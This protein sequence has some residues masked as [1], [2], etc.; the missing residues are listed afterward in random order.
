MVLVC[1]LAGMGKT[2][3]LRRATERLRETH[4]LH[5]IRYD[6]RD[7]ETA[8]SLLDGLVDNLNAREGSDA[9]T[10][11]GRIADAAA[12][13]PS[14]VCIDDLHRARPDAV[15]E[16]LPPLLRQGLRLL[17]A[18]RE[19]LPLSPVALDHLVVQLGPLTEDEASAL[20]S[21]LVDL[22][23]EPATPQAQ[24]GTPFA[25]KQAFG[26]HHPTADDPLGLNDLSMGEAELLSLLCA[27]RQTWPVAAASAVLERAVGNDIRGLVRRLLVEVQAEGLFVHDLVRD[28]VHEGTLRPTPELHRRALA[29]LRIRPADE[30]GRP[31]DP[32][33]LH[34]AL[35]GDVGAASA[36][37]EMLAQ[38]SF[39]LALVGS[40][41]EREVARA[42][43][44]LHELQPLTRGQ[45]CLEIRLRLRQGEDPDAMVPPLEAL[46]REGT[47]VEAE[48]GM[49]LYYAGRHQEAASRLAKSLTA[50]PDWDASTRFALALVASESL[51][52]TGRAGEVYGMLGPVVRDLGLDAGRVAA[53]LSAVESTGGAEGSV[54]VVA[55]LETAT[56]LARGIGIELDR[57]PV[58]AAIVFNVRVALEGR[59][60][61]AGSFPEEFDSNV[62]GRVSA[63]LCE[64]QAWTA[65]GELD[66]AEG[67]NEKADAAARRHGY[68]TLHLWAEA[69]RLELLAL[70]GQPPPAEPDTGSLP[71]TF[72]ASLRSEQR[73][74]VARAHGLLVQGRVDEALAHV[75]QVLAADPV[76]PVFRARAMALR[77]EA[78]WL[79]GRPEEALP[80]HVALAGVERERHQ[81]ARAEVALRMG[82][83]AVAGSM[84]EV[85]ASR[86]LD[87]GWSV[88]AP[89][90]HVL[91][92]ELQLARGQLSETEHHAQLALEAADGMRTEALMARACLAAVAQARAPRSHRTS[93]ALAA[94]EAA[95]DG[96]PLERAAAKLAAGKEVAE[97]S[98]RAAERWAD[99]YGLL[100]PRSILAQRDDGPP[101]HLTAAQAA[102]WPVVAARLDLIDADV[103]VAGETLPLRD[104]PVLLAALTL[105]AAEPGRPVPAERIGRE[106]L[107]L[108][109]HRLDHRSRVSTV[110]RRLRKLLG[111]D[112]IV[113]DGDT[114]LLALPAPWLVLTTLD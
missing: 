104:R 57:I 46:A 6:C 19:Q 9:L 47:D 82:D 97:A 111:P 45:Q 61:L 99:R 24:A 22:Y 108:D 15:R 31:V 73:L 106:V 10:G 68:W 40:T 14:L 29:W 27:M 49:A 109:Y 88:L 75:E 86:V 95:A 92:A 2:A 113:T 110:I 56:Q 37:L 84:L 39:G 77:A 87:R 70:R 17:L 58:L 41:L 103:V 33:E 50:H 4:D 44:R 67:L 23:G 60:A 1:G 79:S 63:R 18:S 21:Y 71:V 52:T 105:L 90:A 54:D 62:F 74:S 53:V 80:E 102:A 34:H 81:L 30:R 89:R 13:R 91:T 93:Q 112:H 65:L 107:E 16:V 5:V 43:Q 35:M 32:E 3:T 8:A 36:M 55:A 76:F 7:G 38:T 83:L 66:R 85:S 26:K 100:D 59:S 69:L 25:L 98:R 114:Y 20:W 101:L 64:V 51:R 96:R 94:L 11:L 78:R 72:T 28:A 48:L 42:V 12:S